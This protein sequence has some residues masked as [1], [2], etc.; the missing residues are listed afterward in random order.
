VGCRLL[1][2]IH[3]LLAPA[4]DIDSFLSSETQRLHQFRRR[5]IDNRD[6]D[7]LLIAVQQQ[8][9]MALAKGD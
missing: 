2:L 9:L 3:L 1:T 7:G 4:F 6:S 5:S 8:R